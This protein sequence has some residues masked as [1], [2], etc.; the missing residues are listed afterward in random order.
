MK[1]K[2]YRVTWEIDVYDTSPEWAAQQANLAMERSAAGNGAVFKVKNME[3]KE[4]KLV[5]MEDI[6]PLDQK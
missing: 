2:H 5:D 3:T 1:P 6:D 4:E